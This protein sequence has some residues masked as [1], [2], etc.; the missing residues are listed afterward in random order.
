[1]SKNNFFLLVL[2]INLCI[3]G[4]T[5][6]NGCTDTSCKAESDE[7]FL[8]S[9]GELNCGTMVSGPDNCGN[10]RKVIVRCQSGPE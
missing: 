2:V 4:F 7:E 8:S 9:F 1:M 10:Y 6:G 5:R 3:L